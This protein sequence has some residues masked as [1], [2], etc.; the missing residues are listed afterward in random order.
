MGVVVVDGGILAG[1]DALDAHVG[2]D[3]DS[4]LCANEMPLCEVG[5]VTYLE[6]DIDACAL[7]QL[8]APEVAAEVV[9]VEQV[10]AVAILRVG[11]VALR[12]VEHIL[13]DVLLH[14]KP[15]AAA[16]EE[17]FALSD[18]VEPIATVG[19][20]DF[21]GFQLNNLS[22]AFAQIAAEEVVVVNLAQEA[23]ALSLRSAEG[24][25]AA[26]AMARTSLFMRCP[27]G[28]MSLAICCVESCERKS[29][30]SF[31]GSLAVAR[32]VMSNV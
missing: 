30:W 24:R 13:F 3:G 5:G 12:D 26:W 18:G 16:E 31:S 22:F 29:V 14:H 21:A 7:V 17:A 20:E 19:A 1:G 27:M 32:K 15:G 2:E 8:A 10:D 25:W 6:F 4:L 28:N 9:E 11:V 23:D